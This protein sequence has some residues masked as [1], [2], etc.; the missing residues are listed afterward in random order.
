MVYPA[1]G[2]IS[3]TW[4][5]S[6]QLPVL[7]QLLSRRGQCLHGSYWWPQPSKQ[8]SVTGPESVAPTG[9]FCR[10]ICLSHLDLME[11]AP[12]VSLF[13]TLFRHPRVC[14]S[15]AFLPTGIES[16]P[17][18]PDFSFAGVPVPFAMAVIKYLTKATS[19]EE[20][21]LAHH[22]RVKS[23]VVGNPRDRSLRPLLTVSVV[24]TWRT[25]NALVPP[26]CAVWVGT[27]LSG[28]VNHI[29]FNPLNQ[30]N[31]RGL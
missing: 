21:M 18:Y 27:R 22:W 15:S 10:D 1:P 16:I 7:W 20:F 31:P 30:P 3:I 17:F 8:H 14:C 12:P 9:C 28:C 5:V 29:E 19:G 25:M 23:I 6:V 11:S 26:S 13:P 4:S 24:R 2:C